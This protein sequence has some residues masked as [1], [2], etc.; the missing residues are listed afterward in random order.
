M[1]SVVIRINLQNTNFKLFERFRFRIK[2]FSNGLFNEGKYI[3][4][5][6]YFS[7]D[8]IT[9]FISIIVCTYKSQNIYCRLGNIKY[10]SNKTSIVFQN[11][12]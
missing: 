5:P 4:L 12:V 7:S 6:I 11:Y 9:D 3:S 1:G 2:T 8:G 10:Q